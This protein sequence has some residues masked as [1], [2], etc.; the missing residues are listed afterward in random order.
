MNTAIIVSAMIEKDGSYLFGKKP[1]D[2]GPY[3]NCWLIIG[4]KAYLEKE[5]IEEAIKREVK[6]ESNIEVSNLRPLH[7]GEDYRTRKGVMSHLVFL[8]FHAKYKS[9]EP[10]PG[11]D[12]AKL[13]WVSEKDCPKLNIAPPTRKLFRFL[14]WI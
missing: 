10:K 14:G 12:I 3:P 9:G 4:G 11:D 7:F 2:V 8:V 13:K 1:K 5:T 6:E